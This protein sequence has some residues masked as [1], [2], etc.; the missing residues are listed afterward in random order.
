MYGLGIHIQA[1]DQGLD[2]LFHG[3]FHDFFRAEFDPVACYDLLMDTISQS[4][5]CR[6][7]FDPEQV[8]SGGVLG[9]PS[10][11][12]FEY[13][14]SDRYRFSSGVVSDHDY[15]T[16]CVSADEAKQTLLSCTDAL[17]SCGALTDERVCPRV[18]THFQVACQNNKIKPSAPS[19]YWPSPQEPGL[20]RREHA[21][22]LLLSE[23]SSVL[24]DPQCLSGSWSNDYGRYPLDVAP[25]VVD[26]ICITHTHP[27]H[28][29]LPSILQHAER[30]RTRVFVPSVEVNALTKENPARMLRA[31]TD[32][33][34][35][36][37]AW[38]DRRSV[39]DIEMIALPFY[40]EQPTRD[41]AIVPAQIRNWGNCYRF[42]LYGRSILVLADSGVDPEGSVLGAVSDS[43]SR[44]GPVDFVLSCYSEF[45]EMINPG[46]PE[47]I[48]TVPF[49]AL[50]SEYRR[51]AAGIHPKS[52]TL[53]MQGLVDVCRAAQA[54][55]FLPY[56]QG[57][58]GLGRNP[59]INGSEQ[60]EMQRLRALLR[61]ENVSTQVLDWCPGEAIRFSDYP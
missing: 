27:D 61:A 17:R 35:V 32:L 14:V 15:L 39:G 40:G 23:N 38:W 13:G 45:P 44:D 60:Q 4:P 26:G 2:E 57:F 28:W 50:R 7:L 18:Q 19:G 5:V 29:H 12:N 25:L 21:S 20:Y 24:T 54:R 9:T 46:L 11:L 8:H 59:L 42:H 58:S 37:T 34:G 56:A 33:D 55:Y 51:R 36:E 22:V 41:H 30:G 16:V 31:L 43:C 3:V 6:A 53:G 49:D 47:F 10:L 52:I 1:D 48:F